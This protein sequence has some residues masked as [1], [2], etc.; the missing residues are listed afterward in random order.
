[1]SDSYWTSFYIALELHRSNALHVQMSLSLV[2]V[3]PNPTQAVD[4][5]GASLLGNLRV[6]NASRAGRR[7]TPSKGSLSLHQPPEY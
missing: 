5:F 3:N 1:M 4:A 7:Q 2:D 6:D